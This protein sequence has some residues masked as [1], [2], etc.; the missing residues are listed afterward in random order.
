VLVGPAYSCVQL[1]ADAIE[2]AGTLD[3]DAVRDAMAASNMM[4]VIGPVTFNGDGTGNVLNPMTQWLDGKM[5]LVWT[6]DGQ[7]TAD[8]GYPAPAFSER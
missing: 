5:E 1:F 8:F 6:S 4:T 7:K 3:R 2:R